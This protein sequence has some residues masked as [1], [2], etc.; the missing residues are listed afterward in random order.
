MRGRDAGMFCIIES[1]NSMRGRYD[2]EDCFKTDKNIP[3]GPLEPDE[4]YDG[5]NFIPA[6]SYGGEWII[7]DYGYA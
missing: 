1:D 2:E 3:L 5:Y 7:V 4:V 6:R